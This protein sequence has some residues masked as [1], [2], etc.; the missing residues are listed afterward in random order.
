MGILVIALCINH[1]LK[2]LGLIM[3]SR[4]DT[5]GNN[6]NDNVI[7]SNYQHD[8]HGDKLHYPHGRKMDFQ[9]LNA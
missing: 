3:E 9:T 2:L 5:T 8:R 4:V 7:I 6:Q 1:Q